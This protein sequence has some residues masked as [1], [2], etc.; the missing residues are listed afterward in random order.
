MNNL[1]KTNSYSCECLIGQ[2]TTETIYAVEVENKEYKD[3]MFI[4]KYDSKEIHEVCS[5]TELGDD[6]FVFDLVNPIQTW[7]SPIEINDDDLMHK[8]VSHFL[9]QEM[10]VPFS[11]FTQQEQKNFVMV[12]P[13]EKEEMRKANT[14]EKKRELI[15]AMR[16]RWKSEPNFNNHDFSLR[17]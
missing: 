5:S 2:L 15:R 8:M 12:S 17:T 4:A 16:R 7:Q 3:R 1:I 9:D 11:L 6:N 13:K 10:K 14:P